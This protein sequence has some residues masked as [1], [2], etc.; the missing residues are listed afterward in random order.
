MTSGARIVNGVG[1]SFRQAE[2]RCIGVSASARA[3]LVSGA[4]G[5]NRALRPA[6]RAQHVGAYLLELRHCGV[7]Q[8]HCSDEVANYV[9]H[10]VLIAL[11]TYRTANPT[12][13]Q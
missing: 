1:S 9:S 4:T 2:G 3:V 5:R 7:R 10:V 12:A 11:R 13:H 8:D 6:A